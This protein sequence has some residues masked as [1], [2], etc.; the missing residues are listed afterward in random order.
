MYVTIYF[1][2]PLVFGEK[3]NKEKY[4]KV[5]SACALAKDLEILSNGDATEIGE[6]G[7]VC[8]SNAVHFIRIFLVVSVNVL[9]SL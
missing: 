1:Y 2:I 9:L 3:F 8:I 4:D 5:I 6:K 7:I